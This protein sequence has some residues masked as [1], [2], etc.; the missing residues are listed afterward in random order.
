M[1]RPEPAFDALVATTEVP[2][3]QPGRVD[4]VAAWLDQTPLRR[5]L[6]RW[7]G[8]LVV[9]LLAAVL[10]LWHLGFPHTLVFDETFY[11]KDAW[12][13]SRLGYEGAWPAGADTGFNAGQVDTFTSAP[14]YV[15]HPPLGKW[16]ISFGLD[17]FG[18]QSS[19]GWRISTAVVG[20]LAVFLLVLIAR[21]LLRSTLLATLA[22]FLFAVDGHAIVLSRISL[23]DNFV[24]F[25]TLLGF[26]AILLDRGQ[27]RVR[28]DRWVARRTDAG[29]DLDWGPTLWARPWL[30]TAGILFGAASAVKW[31]GLYFLAA[32]AIYSVV[33]DAVARKHAGITFWA[34]S[35][36]FRQA[37]AT[38]LL[39]V[40][41]AVAVYLLSWTGWFVTKGGYYREWANEPG[42]AASGFFSWVPRAVQSF[43]HYQQSIYDF[44]VGLHTAHAYQANPFTWLFLTRPTAFSY[45]SV[46]DGVG[47]C[48]DADGCAQFITSIAN[49]LIWWAAT[50]AL[51]YVSY[52]LV[53]YR[54]WQCGLILMGIVAGYLPWLLYAQRTIFQFYAIV[55]E[56]YMILSLVLVI[57]LLLRPTTGNPFD[58]SVPRRFQP[59]GVGVVMV[60][61][62]AVTAISAFFYPI[63]T[64]DQVSVSFI[65]LHYWF[66]GWH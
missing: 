34:S 51:V 13:L 65:Q 21:A 35:A 23:L 14:A 44:N 15:A 43:F 2:W 40:P 9:T 10:R 31:S 47:G 42:N 12:T 60:F 55:F 8:P 25:F 59:G 63:W 38:F 30:V 62:V 20:I 17:L 58:V 48:T 50:A 24:M 16:I 41:V 28:L 4:R 32:F 3:Q 46:A 57:G 64:G 39:T 27:A 37:F 61:V 22:G 19:V 11:V 52:R 36:V 5:W 53:R 56:P 18:A 7:G 26:G 54:E 29:G 45:L 33:V 66:P 49:P 1:T 6:W